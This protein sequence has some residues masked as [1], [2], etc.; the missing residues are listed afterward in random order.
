MANSK[1]DLTGMKDH[2]SYLK[3]WTYEMYHKHQ[4]TVEK[5]DRFYMETVNF[6]YGEDQNKISSVPA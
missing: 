6:L 1:T 2:Q 4:T 3:V 5:T